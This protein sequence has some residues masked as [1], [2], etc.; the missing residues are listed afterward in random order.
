MLGV[1]RGQTSRR[2]SVYRLLVYFGLLFCLISSEKGIDLLRLKKHNNNN[3]NK[4]QPTLDQTRG[5]CWKDTGKPKNKNIIQIL[6]LPST[7]ESLEETGAEHKLSIHNVGSS[8][9]CFVFIVFF[10]CD[11]NSLT[12][13]CLFV[14]SRTTCSHHQELSL[15]IFYTN[16]EPILWRSCMIPRRPT[17]SVARLWASNLM[18]GTFGG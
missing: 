6:C 15:I 3:N 12:L 7:K 10:L 17:C 11:C 8:S 1:G 5:H 18:R 9:T 2:A 16:K 4:V 13:L 14:S